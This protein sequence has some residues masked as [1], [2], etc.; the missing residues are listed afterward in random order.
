MCSSILETAFG[1]HVWATVRLIDA[2]LDLSA[3]ELETNVPGTR[4]PIIETLRHL[5]GSDAFDLFI[6]TNDR[7][8]IVDA[9]GMSLVEARAVMERNG[10]GWA[11]LISGPLDPDAV[12][13]EVDE[14]DGFQRW[15]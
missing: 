8:Y 5:V 14:N 13:R 3:E 4:G 12:V 9:E 11:E 15:A 6:L 7:A 10:G 1:H 2:C